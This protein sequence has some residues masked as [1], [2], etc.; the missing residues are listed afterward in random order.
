MTPE[1]MQEMK[2]KIENNAVALVAVQASLAALESE[3]KTANRLIAHNMLAIVRLE[4][5]NSCDTI[6][7]AILELKREITGS[8]TAALVMNV[9]GTLVMI[10]GNVL[11]GGGMSALGSLLVAAGNV[12]TALS[13]NDT[14]GLTVGLVSLASNATVGVMDKKL[15]NSPDPQKFD[16]TSSGKPGM[17]PGKSKAQKDADV[18]TAGVNG[19]IALLKLKKENANTPMSVTKVV[20]SPKTTGSP[21]DDAFKVTYKKTAFVRHGSG[22]TSAITYDIQTA[23]VEAY[24]L[25]MK[26]LDDSLKAGV[27]NALLDRIANEAFPKLGTNMKSSLH[28]LTKAVLE[29]ALGKLMVAGGAESEYQKITSGSFFSTQKTRKSAQLHVKDAYTKLYQKI[30]LDEPLPDGKGLIKLCP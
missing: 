7:N 6:T 9:T 26:E 24:F 16:L 28:P 20:Y 14:A 23:I 10:G 4:I 19:A 29:K 2:E 8:G 22:G 21:R 15:V 5:A 12:V 30:T 1:E 11:S 25:V 17:M 18:S 13:K 27:K 3:M